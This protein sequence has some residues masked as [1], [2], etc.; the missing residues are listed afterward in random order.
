MKEGKKENGRENI[1]SN[2]ADFSWSDSYFLLKEK[3]ELYK[4]I[5]TTLHAQVLLS[6]IQEH[7]YYSD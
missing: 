3:E 1:F 5:K 7:Q 6:I 2:L 4:E